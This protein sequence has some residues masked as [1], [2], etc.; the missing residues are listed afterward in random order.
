MKRK[1]AKKKRCQVGGEKLMNSPLSRAKTIHSMPVSQLGDYPSEESNKKNL[2]HHHKNNR[3][4]AFVCKNELSFPFSASS[5][6]NW[7]FSCHLVTG[8]EAGHVVTFAFQLVSG[9]LS[10]AER[11]Q[12]FSLTPSIQPFFLPS[13]TKE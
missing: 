6:S 8:D 9:F 11:K 2:K 4:T 13:V 7:M 10:E 1:Y 12:I 3:K 5:H